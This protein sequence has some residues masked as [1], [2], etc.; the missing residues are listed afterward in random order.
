VTASDV[1]VLTPR[2]LDGGARERV[3]QLIGAGLT[4]WTASP[5]L[6]STVTSAAIREFKGLETRVLLLAGLTDLESDET[7]R[8]SYVAA[9]RATS[10]LAVVVGGAEQDALTRLSVDFARGRAARAVS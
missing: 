3:G 5:Q 2:R 8:L 1:V 9:S 4:R 10:L 7:R 6:R